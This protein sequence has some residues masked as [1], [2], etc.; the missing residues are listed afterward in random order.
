MMP[1]LPGDAVLMSTRRFKSPVLIVYNPST[2]ADM[3][4]F[5]IILGIINGC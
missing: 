2:W 5:E 1:L 3:S 4:L